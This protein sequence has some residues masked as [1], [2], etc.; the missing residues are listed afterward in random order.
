[1]HGINDNDIKE[2]IT[3]EH[4]VWLL[5]LVRMHHHLVPRC[6]HKDHHAMQSQWE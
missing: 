4:N 1:M 3:D 2:G 5:Y 6:D